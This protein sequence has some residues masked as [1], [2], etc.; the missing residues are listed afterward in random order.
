MYELKKQFTEYKNVNKQINLLVIREWKLK[1]WLTPS[2][3][4]EDD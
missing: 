2:H 3:L 1:P 4:Y